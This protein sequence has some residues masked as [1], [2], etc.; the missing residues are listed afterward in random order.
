M[1]HIRDLVPTPTHNKLA[2]QVAKAI[3]V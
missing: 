1:A 3:A 2:V